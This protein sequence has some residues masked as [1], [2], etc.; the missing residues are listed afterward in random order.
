MKTERK[1]EF[2]APDGVV[3]EGTKAGEEFDLVCTLR[4][5]SDGQVCLVQVGDTKMPGYSDKD[6][7]KG[8]QSYA[9][10]HAAMTGAGNGN[11]GNGDA[12]GGDTQGAY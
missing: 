5:K 9:D 1:I 2:T 10:E 6:E 4:V 3:P 12:G 7:P 11:G 8:K